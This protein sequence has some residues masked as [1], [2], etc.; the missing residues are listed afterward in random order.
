MALQSWQAWDQSPCPILVVDNSIGIAFVWGK[1]RKGRTSDKAL[2]QAWIINHIP[3]ILSGNRIT[4]LGKPGYMADLITPHDLAHNDSNNQW[5]SN[6][7]KAGNSLIIKLFENNKI[8]IQFTYI[9][10]QSLSKSLNDNLFHCL[11]CDTDT[12]TMLFLSHVFLYIHA[13][14]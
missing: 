1:G 13:G 3:L 8:Y 4:C 5:V 12:W 10:I 9:E 6:V 14:K 7:Q 2:W 11:V